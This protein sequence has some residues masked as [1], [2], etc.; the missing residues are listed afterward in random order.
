M[1]LPF[2]V[3]SSVKFRTLKLLQLLNVLIFIWHEFRCILGR[4]V[5]TTWVQISIN[6]SS[7]EVMLVCK[8]VKSQITVES[9]QLGC[10]LCCV[11][12]WLMYLLV[13][14]YLFFTLWLSLSDPSLSQCDIKLLLHVLHWWVVISKPSLT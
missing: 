3:Q 4:S 2:L 8:D 13:L 14:G 1:W 7:C 10:F 12:S 6:I 9:R 5:Y 11:D